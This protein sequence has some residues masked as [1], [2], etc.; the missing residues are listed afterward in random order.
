MKLAPLH[1]MI[2]GL[3]I[4]FTSIKL[5][6]IV[7]DFLEILAKANKPIILLLMGIYLSFTFEKKQVKAILKSI[8]IRYFVGFLTIG[9][10]LFL[11]PEPSLFRSIIIICVIL[12]FGMTLLTFSDEFDFDHKLPGAIVNITT[13]I[14]FSLIWLLVWALALN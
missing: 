7:I 13:L 1:G 2:I 5:P 4:N 6:V 12:P 10:I 3:I 8:T 9:I 14:S 11:V